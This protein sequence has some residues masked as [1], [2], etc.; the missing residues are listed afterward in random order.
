M[1]NKNV[2]MVVANEGFKDEEYF[3][4][5]DILRNNGIQVITA[6]LQAGKA[7]SALGQTVIVDVAARYLLE[8]EDR[9]QKFDAIVFIGGQGMEPLVDNENFK[10]LAINFYQAHKIIAAIC[11]AP[12]ILAKAGIL[13]GKDA[14]VFPSQEYIDELVNQGAEYIR[15]DL[16]VSS[17]II[18]ASGPKAVYKFGLLLANKLS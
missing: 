18:T 9:W 4:P 1:S 12:L 11:V 14:T 13:R 17:N 8:D 5:I 3:E 15:E 6:A 16:V 10:Q 7:K 2:L